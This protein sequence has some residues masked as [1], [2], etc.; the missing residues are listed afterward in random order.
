MRYGNKGVISAI[1][2]DYEMP[3]IRTGEH[4]TE[5]VDIIFNTLGVFNR[6]N[7]FQ[8][9][10]QS[11]TFVCDKMAIYFKTLDINNS[12]DLKKMEEILFDIIGIFNH[13]QRE[14]IYRG[15]KETCKTKDAKKKFFQRVID[16]GVN[17]HINPF[18]HKENLYEAIKTCYDKYEWIQPYEVYFFDTIS[19]RWVRQINRQIIGSMYIMVLKQNSKKGL[20]VCATAPINKRGLPD[21]TDSAKKHKSIVQHTPIRSGIKEWSPLIAI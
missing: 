9:D 8:L 4:T 13:E 18:W 3:R 21:K 20:S 7:I 15:Y 11:I 1:R 12:K 6:L 5:Q 19:K 16:E 17:I 14:K 2:E 10:E